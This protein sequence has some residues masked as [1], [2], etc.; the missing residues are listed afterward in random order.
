MYDKKDILNI[1]KSN[2][3]KLANNYHVN[4][5]GLFGSYSRNSQT[6]KSDIDLLVEF[7]KTPSLIKFFILQDFLSSLLDSNVDLVTV[8]ALKP[9]LKD[10]IL[11]DVIYI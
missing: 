6:D 7:S 9:V 3:E 2:K 8:K 4:K 5:M 1:L 10:Q 11:K